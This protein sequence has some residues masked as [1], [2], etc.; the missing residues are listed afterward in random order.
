MMFYVL[1]IQEKKYNKTVR[2]LEKNQIDYNVLI[3]DCLDEKIHKSYKENAIVYDTEF[4]KSFVDFCGT[5]I[6]NGA[7]VGRVASIIEAKKT[8]I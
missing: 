6:T 2:Y 1:S 8:K 3:P 4:C 7:S 5:N